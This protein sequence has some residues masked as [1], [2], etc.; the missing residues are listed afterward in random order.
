MSQNPYNQQAL[1]F[2]SVQNNP[3]SITNR[4]PKDRNIW[5]LLLR[6]G[7]RISTIVRPDVTLESLT[8]VRQAF[9]LDTRAGR[10]LTPRYA[11]CGIVRAKTEHGRTGNERVDR[12]IKGQKND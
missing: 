7:L 8:Y 5:I 9:Q 10:P 1:Y 3:T 6:M 12:K 11:C 2:I 4:Q